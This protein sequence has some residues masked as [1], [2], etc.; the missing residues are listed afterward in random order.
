MKV[1]KVQAIVLRRTN[2]GEA[3]R[4]V[5]CITPKGRRGFMAKGV[6]KPRS[7]L[8][9]GIELFSISELIIRQG[10]GELGIL[11]SAR[12]Q[13]FYRHILEDYDRLS[14]AYEVLKRV[15]QGSEMVDDAEWYEVTRQVLEALDN[16]DSS[17]PLIKTWFY[18]HYAKV[19]GQDLNIW[20]DIDG[21]KLEAGVNYRYDVVGDSFVSDAR[22][23]VTE[24]HIKVL[25]VL[26][27]K[28]LQ[29]GLRVSGSRQY[30]TEL[31]AISMHHAG[32]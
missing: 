13:I 24:N 19:S 14:F 6:R 17:L 18:L 8:A 5:Q 21:E 31:L 26:H 10:R 1:E 22:G 27:E 20:R 16:L 2:Y 11:S 30:V 9:G 4:V 12:M 7:K 32:I 15:G 29:V 3:D 28:P 25:R 23:L